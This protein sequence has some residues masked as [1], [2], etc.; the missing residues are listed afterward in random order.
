MNE[1]ADMRARGTKEDPKARGLGGWWGMGG[2]TT[3]RGNCHPTGTWAQCLWTCQV[4]EKSHQSGCF[5]EVSQFSNTGS[6]FKDAE[7]TAG[8]RKQMD[9]VFPGGPVVKAPHFYCKGREFDPWLEN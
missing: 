6:L 8:P 9:R 1:T 3:G 2:W 7:D 4:F 5:C